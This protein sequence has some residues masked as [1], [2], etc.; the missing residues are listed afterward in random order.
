VGRLVEV[1]ATR[2]GFNGSATIR[3]MVPWVRHGEGAER[4]PQIL[5]S[6][7]ANPDALRARLG[8]YRTVMFGDSP[9]TRAEREAMAVAVA[10]SR[11]NDCHC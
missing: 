3:R 5:A 10:V 6:H 11:T 7:T 1:I 8:L 2:A 4:L 9:L